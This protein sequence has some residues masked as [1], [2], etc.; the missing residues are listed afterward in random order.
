MTATS[1]ASTYDGYLPA[2]QVF[3]MLEEDFLSAWSGLA[4]LPPDRG[5]GG[6]NFVFGQLAMVGLELACRV[7]HADPAGHVLHRFSEGL[8]DMDP[9]YLT[10]LPGEVRVPKDFGLPTLP[11]LPAAETLLALLFDLIRNGQAHQYHQ[12]PARLADNRLLFLALGGV[13]KGQPYG[14]TAP[15]RRAQHLACTRL[16]QTGN[17][18]LVVLPDVLFRDIHHASHAVLSHGLKPQWFARDYPFD[19]NA[20]SADLG[21]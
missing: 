6:G 12:I 19:S 7:A 18:Q 20:L 13:T 17:L 1:A 9:R 10:R 2:E 3:S 11:G 14:E 8:R 21:C 5:E 15:A 16:P 4:E